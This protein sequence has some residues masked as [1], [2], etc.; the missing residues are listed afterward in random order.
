MAMSKQDFIGMADAIIRHN[1]ESGEKFRSEHIDTLAD[2]CADTNA[3]FKRDR[4]VRYINGECGPNG[5]PVKSTTAR[6]VD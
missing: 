4:W 6:K 3:R 2:F 1:R 5:G